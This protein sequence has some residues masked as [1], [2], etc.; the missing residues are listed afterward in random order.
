M[1]KWNSSLAVSLCFVIAGCDAVLRIKGVAPAEPCTLNLI[2]EASGRTAN[3]FVVSGPFEQRVMFPG[4]WR[5]PKL[6]I[7]AECRGKFITTVVNPQF[8]EVDLG[9]LEP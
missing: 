9:R 2:D 7:A 5:A 4:A 1:K 3:T 6:S 8:P